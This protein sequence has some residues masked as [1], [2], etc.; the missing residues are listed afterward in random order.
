MAG[1]GVHIAPSPCVH[2]TVLLVG[3]IQVAAVCV[4]VAGLEPLR[5]H[6]LRFKNLVNIFSSKFVSQIEAAV[7]LHL[8][9]DSAAS[10]ESAAASRTVTRTRTRTQT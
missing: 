5:L 7:L 3:L 9:R 4:L 6:E 8:F 1:H 10:S 2:L